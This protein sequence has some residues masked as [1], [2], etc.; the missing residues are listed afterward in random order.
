MPTWLTNNAPWSGGSTSVNVGGKVPLKVSLAACNG[1][2]P[3]N[4]AP[5]YAVTAASGGP[6]LATGSLRWDGDKYVGQ[7]DTSSLPGRGTYTVT[8]TVP[9]TGQ[10]IVGTLRVR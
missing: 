6:V 3:A 1:S 9:S 4:L 8:V 5:T 2:K 10:K 7:F